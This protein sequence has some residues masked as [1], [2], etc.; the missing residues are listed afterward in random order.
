MID[1]KSDLGR[2]ARKLLDSEYVIWFTTVGKDG[3]P[4]PRPVWFIPYNDGVLIYS[5]PKTGK[6]AHIRR[7][8]Q[9]SLHFNT[10]ARG[11][12]TVVVFTG[13]AKLDA[14]V[15]ARDQVPAYID[16]YRQGILD[17]DYTIEQFAGAYVQAIRVDLS[18]LRGW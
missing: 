3:T 17:L 6:V 15:P 16:K 14:S 7:Q 11:D 9:V 18:S 2:K 5:Q 10:D 12:E 8:P 13:T 1:W 4:Q